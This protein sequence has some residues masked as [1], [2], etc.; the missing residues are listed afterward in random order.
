MIP[1][2]RET[3]DS[4]KK[5]GQTEEGSSTSRRIRRESTELED[6][7]FALLPLINITE[8]R[9]NNTNIAKM[10]DGVDDGQPDNQEERAKESP[11]YVGEVD[12]S[13]RVSIENSKAQRFLN[14]IE[15]TGFDLGISLMKDMESGECGQLE[16]WVS[17][18]RTDKGK[19]KLFQEPSDTASW[20]NETSAS[21]IENAQP[22]RVMNTSLPQSTPEHDKEKVKL[23]DPKKEKYVKGDGEKICRY[24]MKPLETL[25]TLEILEGL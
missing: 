11:T 24:D 22:L 21:P 16:A 9:A 7:G 23:L 2:E 25:T 1:L 19:A 18:F 12:E 14:A 5:H 3:K 13:M 6:G 15:P 10:N 20:V 8:T 4:R 17:G